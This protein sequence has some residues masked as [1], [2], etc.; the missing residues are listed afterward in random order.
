M[1]CDSVCCLFLFFFFHEKGW[2][3]GVLWVFKGRKCRGRTSLV[4]WTSPPVWQGTT[5]IGNRSEQRH[6]DIAINQTKGSC[7]TVGLDR[8]RNSIWL[9]EQSLTYLCIAR[10]P[11]FPRSTTYEILC[12]VHTSPVQL[13][14]NGGLDF[15]IGLSAS[16]SNPRSPCWQHAVAERTWRW[17]V[18]RQRIAA[19]AAVYPCAAEEEGAGSACVSNKRRVSKTSLEPAHLPAATQS[20]LRIANCMLF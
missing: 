19:A 16:M 3:L 6:A 8:C 13:M 20:H 2:M 5:T 17:V 12:W 9:I 11:S 10:G 1:R 18:T 7:G 14:V 4:Q 15:V